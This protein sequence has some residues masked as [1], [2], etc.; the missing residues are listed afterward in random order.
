MARADDE[1]R[2]QPRRTAQRCRERLL[3]RTGGWVGAI[4]GRSDLRIFLEHSLIE[5]AREQFAVLFEDGH[6][7]LDDG[8]G[9]FGQHVGYLLN[10]KNRYL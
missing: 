9:L 1:W 3:L 8:D 10:F 4:E 7:G 6:D 5:V 2:S